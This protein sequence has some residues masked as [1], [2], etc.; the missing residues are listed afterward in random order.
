MKYNKVGYCNSCATEKV[1][2]IK[3]HD[4]DEYFCE[5]CYE[6]YAS[7]PYMYPHTLRDCN[8][9]I[10]VIAQVGNIIRKDIKKLKNK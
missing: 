5:I 7:F 3:T 6:T 1:P 8:D 4:K 2:V 9:I 10:K